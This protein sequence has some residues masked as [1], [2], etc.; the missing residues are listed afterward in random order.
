MQVY[1]WRQFLPATPAAFYLLFSC[2]CCFFYLHIAWRI[3]AGFFTLASSTTVLASKIQV[4]SDGSVYS[5]F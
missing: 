1:N 5:V 4:S 2:I 3:Y